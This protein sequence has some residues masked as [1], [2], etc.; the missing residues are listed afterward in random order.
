VDTDGYFRFEARLKEIIK[1]GGINVSPLE[2]EQLLLRHASIRQAYVMGIPD[3]KRGEMVVAV[4]VAPQ[5]FDESELRRYLRENAAS[6]KMPTHFLIR[7]DAEIPRLATG[8]VA[9][10]QLRAHA[11]D[12]IERL[13][14]G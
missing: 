1:V 8:K 7:T 4:V 10:I 2:V 11:I 14:S 12:E 5:G 13:R 3:S 9:R 6:F